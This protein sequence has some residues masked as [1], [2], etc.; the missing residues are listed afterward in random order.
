MPRYSQC[1]PWR[2]GLDL[3]CDLGDLSRT[4]LG[5]QNLPIGWG[6]RVALISISGYNFC[7]LFNDDLSS[8]CSFANAQVAPTAAGGMSRLDR[9]TIC[10][11]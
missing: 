11:L 6:S 8:P 5:L 2:S 10:V 7:R 4:L 1:K 9:P 3:D